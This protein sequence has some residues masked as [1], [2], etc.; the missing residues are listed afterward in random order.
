MSGRILVKFLQEKMKLH[1]LH[2]EFGVKE[3]QNFSEE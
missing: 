2:W 3:S 1:N